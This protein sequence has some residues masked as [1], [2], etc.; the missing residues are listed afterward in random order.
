MGVCGGDCAEDADADGICDDVDEC[1]GALD[2]CD[3]CNGP[4]D[5]YECGCADIPAGDCDCDG[6]QL[7]A[8]G[9]C[10]GDCAAD[11]DADGICDD[12]D[13][14]VGELDECGVCNGPGAVFTCGCTAIPE[15]DC[16]CDGNQLDALGVCGG[17]CAED[18]DADGICDNLDECVGTLDACGICNGPGD[19]YECG[20]ADIPE[21]D[22]DCD[23]NQLDALGVCGG[24]CAEDA[25]A[26]GICDDEDDCVD[27]EAPTWFYFPAND[28][29]SCSEIMPSVEE[30]MPIAQDDCGPVDVV[31]LSDG[32]FEYPFG[33]SQS[34][35]C[36]RV[37]QATD[38][39]GNVL[40]DTL[41]IT[42]LDTIAPNFLYPTDASLIINE[43]EGEVVPGLEAFVIDN[44]DINAEYT[45]QSDTIEN[46][47][48]VMM[49]Q[50]T[51]NASDACGNVAEFVQILTV[52][53]AFGGC[54]DAEACNF[55][56]EA[57]VDDGACLYPVVGE[58][59]DGN[60]LSDVDGDGFCD[61]EV[62]GCTDEL[63]CNFSALATEDDGTC[64]YCSCQEDEFDGY[65]LLLE[66]H[67]VHEAGE[68]AGMTT[69]RMYVTTPTSTDVI[70][71]IFGDS[72]TTLVIAS[73]TDFYQNSLGSSLGSN[74]SPLLF[75]TFPELAFDSWLTIGL[76]AP[77]QVGEQAPSV[78]ENAEN[79][80][81]TNFEAGQDIVIDD[82][83]GGAVYVVNDGAPNI[84]SGLDQRILIGQ[85]TTDGVMS[86]V[87]NLQ[88][89]TE[90]DQ[91]NAQKPLIPFDGIGWVQGSSDI[92]CGCMDP[93]ACNFNGEANN[94]DGS[95]EFESCLGCT[96]SEACNFEDQATVDD[97]SCVYPEFL[98][99]DCAGNCLADNDLDGVCDCL[100]FPGCTDPVACNFDPINTDDAGNCYYAEEFYDC[101]GNCLSDID[102][103]GTCDELEVF[104][105]TDDSFCNFNPEATEDDGSC[106]EDDQVN[107][108]CEGAL[109]ITCG[110]TLMADNSDCANEDDVEGCAGDLASNPTAGLWFT[111]AGTGYPIDVTTCY[112][113]TLIDTYMS[114]FEGGCNGL[115]C[116]GGNDDQSEPDY[117][118]LC[119]TSFTASTVNVD[120]QLGV[121]YHVL[122]QGVFGEAG[123]FE[124][125]LE[126]VQPGCTDEE[127]CNFDPAATLENGSCDYPA[128]FYDCQG[129][130]LADTDGDGICNELEI[131]GCTDPL[132]S[133]YNDLATEA[134]GNCQYCDLELTIVIEQGLICAGDST[135]VAS[136]SM[137]G[138]VFPD[139][140]VIV[141]NG[142]LQ[143]S[144]LF[145]GLAA[146]SYTAVVNQGTTCEALINFDIDEGQSLELNVQT[147]DV[148]CF[149]DEN[150]VIS[151][152][153]LSGTL[154]ITYELTGP[155]SEVNNMGQ[156]DDLPP[157]NYVLLVTDGL[158]CQ[159]AYELSIGEPA[160]LVVGANITDAAVSGQGAIDLVVAGGTPPYNF[161]W[162][163]STTFTSEE[164]DIEGLEAP[165][166][167]TVLV[168]DDRGCEVQSGPYTIDDV[169]GVDELGEW[170]FALYPNP[171]SQQ[172]HL[173]LSDTVMDAVMQVF[174][175]SGRV[176]WSRTSDHW[177]GR[178][179]VDVANWASGT[180]HVQVSTSKRVAHAQFMVQH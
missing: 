137:T 164:E 163:S 9:V 174:D 58:D 71:A 40:V 131:V 92:V 116:I 51:F 47:D 4:G 128:A 6:N 177:T 43:V 48:G 152:V 33:C 84:V 148:S 72:D 46:E 180:Y 100:E 34:Y 135:A 153:A 32:P 38:A 95:C 83:V 78:I 11:A 160:A 99:V 134:G 120:S 53:Q 172:M 28:T 66:Q 22:C 104:G 142:V 175:A 171:A 64:E 63:A 15:G 132:A 127:A 154:P 96:D 41:Q 54:L 144:T 157:G 112:P 162:T 56:P 3:V 44:C 166:D 88:M 17:D 70:S 67:A 45:A 123:S 149:G 21:G 19:I 65:G 16:D 50:R 178:F 150:G 25:D 103:D 13:E 138:V 10:G 12:V 26:D 114:V 159:T 133:N 119:P 31:W 81:L 94:E 161:S 105:C 18:L 113:G 76:D 146:G 52:I 2:A 179:S 91:T 90:G 108:T 23:G 80:W 82:A 145:E 69:Y 93:T 126:C 5:I 79:P 36:P 37:Y 117:D 168:T 143:D 57:N 35:L 170:V 122:V 151:A 55:D 62:V 7:D 1:V 102:G 87:V 169:Y 118:D 101:D 89:F 27:M 29:I 8:L 61:P 85:F 111:F 68:L 59:C 107:D 130:C 106:G 173:E 121:I 20:C 115:V 14:C 141:L 167:Y 156:Y 75:P 73:T 86:G 165:A 42:V 98:C 125:G 110:M 139:S 24:D 136:L 129:D 176:I 30:T 155:V 147:T 109:Q 49:I 124:V 158:G 74:I 140:I 97:G 77:A 39:A 60:C